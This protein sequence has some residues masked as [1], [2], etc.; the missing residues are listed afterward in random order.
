[1]NS[2]LNPETKIPWGPRAR[3][4]T[5]SYTVTMPIRYTILGSGDTL[6]TP[7]AGCKC[8]TCVHPQSKRYRFGLLIEMD[9]TKILVDPNPDLKWQC[10]DSKLEL[11]DIDHILVTHQHS[12]HING[13]GEFFYRRSKPTELWYGDYPLNHKLIEYWRY[14]E[15]EEIMTFNTYQ[16]NVAFKLKPDIE[17]LPLELNHGFPTCGFIVRHKGASLAVVTDTNAKLP[18]ETIKALRGVD[19]LFADAFSENLEQ[20]ESVYAEC[21][22]PVPDLEKDWYHMTFSD[23]LKLQQA[24]GAKRTYAIHISRHVRPHKELIETYQTESFL[25]GSDGLRGACG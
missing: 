14:L 16:P 19:V 3:C 24:T 17:I 23:I 25:I 7:L 18:P 20:V 15:Q 13:L 6:G 5:T 22:L 12:D 2:D 9:D 1:M 21:N 8:E 10:L 4:H 11:K